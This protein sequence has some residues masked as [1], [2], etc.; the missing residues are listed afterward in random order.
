MF[1]IT[2]AEMVWGPFYQVLAVRAFAGRTTLAMGM[3]TFAWGLAEALATVLGLI[4]IDAG[5]GRLSIMLGAGACVAAAATALGVRRYL[6]REDAVR[7]EDG[8]RSQEVHIREESD[9]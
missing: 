3:I 7:P 8:E 9:R 5:T 6:P 2:A 1:L 4:L